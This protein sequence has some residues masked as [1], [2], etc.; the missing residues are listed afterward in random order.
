MEPDYKKAFG[1]MKS[2]VDNFDLRETLGTKLTPDGGIKT[3]KEELVKIEVMLMAKLMT[4]KLDAAWQPIEVIPADK[5]FSMVYSGR[6]QV[7][8]N[9]EQGPCAH[10]HFPSV[11]VKKVY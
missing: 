1:E 5:G 2:F 8:E 6:A 9:Y 10:F 7:V 11:I 3:D 4:L